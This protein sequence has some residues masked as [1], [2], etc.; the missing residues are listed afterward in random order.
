MRAFCRPF[1]G[2]EAFAIPQT[3]PDGSP[4][5][6]R[7][8]ILLCAFAVVFGTLVNQGLTMKGIIRLLRLSDDDPVSAEVRTGRTLTYQELL[9]SI[10][11]DDSPHAVQLRNE[12]Q[13][14]IELNANADLAQP[15]NEVPGGPLKRHAIAAAYRK[16]IELRSQDVIGDQAY[17]TLVQEL[18]WTNLH[19]GGNASN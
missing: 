5:P 10:K 2:A 12:Y 11:A 16:A 9:D 7:D 3:L 18:D 4:F 14:V 13:L 15:L 19:A 1:P 8:L 6:Y 17:R